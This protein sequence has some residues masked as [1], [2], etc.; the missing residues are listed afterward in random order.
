MD[1]FDRTFLPAAAE[2]GL[3][4]QTVSRHMPVFRRCVRAD[5]ATILVARCTRPDRPVSGEY[6][7]LMTYQRLVVTRQSPL[8]HRLHL[9]LNTELRHLSNVT[10]NPDSRLQRVELSATAIDGARE[11]FL[12]R[13]EHPKQV[14]QIDT[15]L[16][17][18]FRSRLRLPRAVTTA[19]APVAGHRPANGRPT[20]GRPVTGRRPAGR[21]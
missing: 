19:G 9:H 21:G 3:A 5:D 8:L 13:T 1:V 4:V 10:W 2:T 6:L 7:L 14:W 15:L 12:I 11:R 18:A 16:D 20:S 17:H